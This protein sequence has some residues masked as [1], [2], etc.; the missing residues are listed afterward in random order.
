LIR[1]DGSSE[2]QA[3]H[4]QINVLR[5]AEGFFQS[6]VLFALLRL[7]VLEHIGDGDKPLQEL[8]LELKVRPDTLDRLLHAGVVFK[9]LETQDGSTYRAS[10]MSRSVLLP[11]AGDAYLGDWLRNLEYF[12]FALSK[13]D[14]AVLTSAPT[15]DPSFH[16]GADSAQTEEFILAMHNYGALRGKELAHYLDTA[17]AGSLL[18]LGC[19]SGVYAFHLGMANTRLELFLLD[20]SSVLEVAKKV[21]ARYPLQN[22]VHYLPANAVVDEIPGSYDVIL[23][24][25]TLHMLGHE[26]S[27]VLLK[28]LYKS[29]KP[30]GSIVIQAQFLR[31][32]RLGDRWPVLLDLIQMCI[33]SEGAN[34]SVAETRQWLEEAGFRD[35]EYRRMSLFNTNSFLRGH[36]P[37]PGVVPSISMN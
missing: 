5:L 35:I 14:Q 11:S 17:G 21:Q 8:A 33:T 15:V 36:K 10:A 34:H 2:L 32:D 24:S 30:G 23:I 20:L 12:D 28:R 27:R 22:D 7:R 25:N 16:L 26:A 19:G 18:D 31:D 6:K 3:I 13:M 9:L 29:V 4:D 37:G 1:K